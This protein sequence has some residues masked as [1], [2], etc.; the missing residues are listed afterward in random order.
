MVCLLYLDVIQMRLFCRLSWRREISVDALDS[1]YSTNNPS[2]L[3]VSLL[4]GLIE[5]FFFSFRTPRNNSHNVQPKEEVKENS[6]MRVRVELS[7]VC[8]QCEMI[9][10]AFVV[11]KSFQ[12][13]YHAP[14]ESISQYVHFFTRPAS[15]SL[16]CSFVHARRW[17]ECDIAC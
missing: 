10:L 2:F 4:Y 6:V 13:N 17:L 11:F 5:V 3:L 15:P 9:Q 12:L 7:C 16:T 1:I 8:T 14:K